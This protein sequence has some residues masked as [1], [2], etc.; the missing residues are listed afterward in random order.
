MNITV[1][2]SGTDAFKSDISVA[3]YFEDFIPNKTSKLFDLCNLSKS[4]KLFS[5]KGSL[6]EMVVLPCENKAQ[7]VMLIGLG[8]KSEYNYETLRIAYSAAITQCQTLHKESITLIAPEVLNG[9]EE[10]MELSFTARLTVYEFSKFKKK[11]DAREIKTVYIYSEEGTSEDVK[12]GNVIGEGV[13]FARDLANMPATTGTPSYFVD[14]SRQIDGL[15]FEV[16]ER[17]DFIKLGMGGLEAVSRGSSEPAKLLIVKYGNSKSDP[18]MFV[19]KGI[20][21]DSGGISIKPSENLANLK[22]DKAGAAAVIGAIKAIAELHMK[23]NVV[24]LM[25]LTENMPDGKA[26]KPGDIV[27]H[28]NHVTSEIISTDAEGRLI[29]ADALSYGIEK[30]S[31][32]IVVDIATLTGAKMVALGQNTAA[33]MGNNDEL[34]EKMT[35]AAKRSWEMLWP[36][37]LTQEFKDLIKSDVADIKNSGGKFAGAETAAAF[38]SYFVGNVPW[39]HLDIPGKTELLG[40]TVRNYLHSGASGFGV[41]LLVEFASAFSDNP[42]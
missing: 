29:L 17:D 34:M 10:A 32:R 11:K 23:I 8:K 5:F 38:L 27:M 1:V 24:G 3:P 21:F 7:L 6:K 2:N 9:K 22:Y 30:F 12:K 31:P 26:Y 14:Q 28:Y 36:L 33:I 19:G 25:P 13:N 40:T 35:A 15:I 39:V 41:R 42:E 16:L 37:P 20:T 18:V 4:I